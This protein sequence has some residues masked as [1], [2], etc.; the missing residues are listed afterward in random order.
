MEE[1]SRDDSPYAPYRFA[2]LGNVGRLHGWLWP[3]CPQWFLSFSDAETLGLAVEAVEM[4]DWM[5]MGALASYQSGELS[6]ALAELVI[7]A[8]RQ[9]NQCEADIAKEAAQ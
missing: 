3:W 5:E 6:A 8:K 4:Y 1:N 7:T 2:N 9:R